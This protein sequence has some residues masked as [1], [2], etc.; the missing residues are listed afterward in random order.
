M[1]VA[2]QTCVSTLS[3]DSCISSGCQVVKGSRCSSS[4]LAPPCS[5]TFNNQNNKEC[6]DPE[7][8]EDHVHY[9]GCMSPGYVCMTQCIQYKPTGTIYIVWEGCSFTN[10]EWKDVSDSSACD[11]C[12]DFICPNQAEDDGW[13]SWVIWIAVISFILALLILI[14]VGVFTVAAFLRWKYNFAQGNVYSPMVDAVEITPS[15]QESG[16]YKTQTQTQTQT[17]QQENYIPVV[18]TT[19]GNIAIKMKDGSVRVVT[20]EAY[21]KMYKFQYLKRKRM[22]QLLQLRKQQQQQQQQPQQQQNTEDQ[23]SE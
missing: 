13:I 6:C 21:E 2:G 19:D 23:S 18:R 14:I 22:L 20:P 10:D 12:F 7:Q 3:E 17:L 4:S 11:S 9:L 1:G 5:L 15:E 8:T 16:V